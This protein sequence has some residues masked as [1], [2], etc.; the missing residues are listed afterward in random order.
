MR[1]L[2]DVIRSGLEGQPE[3]AALS[4]AVAGRDLTDVLLIDTPDGRVYTVT[5]REVR[6]D[7]SERRENVAP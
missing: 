6:R 4:Q 1:R 2:L 5:V 3:V 7:P